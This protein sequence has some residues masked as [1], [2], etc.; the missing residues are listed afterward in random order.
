VAVVAGLAL[1]ALAAAG[2]ASA[3]EYIGT[4]AKGGTASISGTNIKCVRT[5][6]ELACYVSKGGKPSANTYA[7]TISD[8]KVEAG[9]VGSSK[10]SYTSPKQP[11]AGGSPETSGVKQ[12][13]VKIGK[14]FGAVGTHAACSV[15]SVNGKT[16][17]ACTLVDTRGAVAGAYGVVLTT[18]QIQVRTTEGNQSKVLYDK[19]F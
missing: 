12:L 5:P 10:P 9:K 8:G 1:L 18:H 17:V 6:T 15:L 19:M 3:N 2:A 16:G 14:N 4:L 7:A 11:K 13:N